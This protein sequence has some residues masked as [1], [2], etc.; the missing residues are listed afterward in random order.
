ML[1]EE[2]DLVYVYGIDIVPPTQ[3]CDHFSTQGPDVK[4][5]STIFQTQ[6]N[7]REK[8]VNMKHPC[9]KCPAKQFPF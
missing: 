8:S 2:M 9:L 4:V 3:Q 5:K 1:Q 6:E 7:P